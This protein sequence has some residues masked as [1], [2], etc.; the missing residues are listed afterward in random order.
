MGKA[1]LLAGIAFLSL[2]CANTQ[3]FLNGSFESTTGTCNYNISNASFN[4]MMNNCTGF[5]IGSQIDI[6]QTSCGYGAAQQGNMLIALAIAIDNTSYDALSLTL[7]A[8]LTAGTSYTVSFYHRKHASYVSNNMELGYSTT[9]TTFG[10]SIGTVAAPTSTSWTQVS[11][12]F[13]PTFATSYITARIIPGA[14]GWNHV[15]NFTIVANPLPV[16]LVSFTA[17]CVEQGT[18]LK[19][20]T[21]SEK[22]N[23]YFTLE[24]SIDGIHYVEQ[25]TIPGAGNSNTIREYNETILRTPI[26]QEYYRLSQTDHDGTI[27]HFPPIF[28]A[29]HSSFKDHCPIVSVNSDHATFDIYSSQEE[30]I[31]L[32]LIDASGR[33][34]QHMNLELVKGSNTIGV[35][36]SD[37]AAGMYIAMI[38]GKNIQCS[39]KF[40]RP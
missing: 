16:E 21:A 6:M 20:S 19:W 26:P 39:T 9:S 22:N 40:F 18:L 36:L 7:S 11:F 24:S 35:N 14:Y 10:T 13:T 23:A 37:L 28:I 15:D 29:C 31:D 2:I 5:G 30:K 8:P 27:Q 17:E 32:V 38:Y 33:T 25:A 3:T 34:H 1:C 12:S 4:S